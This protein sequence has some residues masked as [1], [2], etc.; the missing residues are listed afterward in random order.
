VEQEVRRQA[1]ERQECEEEEQRQRYREA[2]EQGRQELGDAFEFV[3]AGKRATIKGLMKE[4][5]VKERLDASINKCL[6][7]LIMVRGIKSRASNSSSAEIPALER[8][9]K[10]G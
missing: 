3:L 7:Q 10:A 2:V 1:A 5:D 8:P 4:L 6:K 9:R